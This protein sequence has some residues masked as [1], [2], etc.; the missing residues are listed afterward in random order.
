M[1]SI[2]NNGQNASLTN[3]EEKGGT[4]VLD[5]L[6]RAAKRG[7]KIFPCNGR[8]KP[9]VAWSQAATTDVATIEAW[10]KQW[11]G[12]LWARALP[13]DVLLIDLDRKHG[14]NGPKEFERLQGYHPD[15]Y[16][17]PRAAT[18]TGGI[19]IYTNAAGRDFKNSVSKIA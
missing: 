19:H 8:K 10:A 16:D 13:P 14:L 2:A 6:L 7:W 5:A 17:A 18:G 1:G 3:I 11:P 15:L 4:D 12:A 9:L